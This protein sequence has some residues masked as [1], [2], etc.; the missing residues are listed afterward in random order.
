MTKISI[1]SKFCAHTHTVSGK[2]EWNKIIVKIDTS[3]EK[4]KG[5]PNLEFPIMEF[6]K[7]REKKIIELAKYRK[8][9]CSRKCPIPYA[10][11]N[12]CNIEK[13]FANPSEENEESL[14][15]SGQKMGITEKLKS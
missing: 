1:S 9:D 11:L 12:V 2:V 10:I 6:S 4:F 14:K 8:T 7:T 13:G 3:C 5:I 15:N